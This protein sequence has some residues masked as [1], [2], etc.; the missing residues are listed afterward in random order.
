MGDF[1]NADGVTVAVVLGANEFTNQWL[2]YNRPKYLEDAVIFGQKS[3][4]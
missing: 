1:E 2:G 4:L 3:L